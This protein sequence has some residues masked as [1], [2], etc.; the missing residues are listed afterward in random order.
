M[1]LTTLKQSLLYG[2]VTAVLTI[3]FAWTLAVAVGNQEEDRIVAQTTFLVQ[4]LEKHRYVT[5]CILVED[6]SAR[7][8]DTLLTCLAEANDL[9]PGRS[10]E[11]QLIENHPY[12]QEK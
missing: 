4:E 8:Q 10:I 2:I 1:K 5:D 6:I 9:D 7:T 3:S 11:E 12:L